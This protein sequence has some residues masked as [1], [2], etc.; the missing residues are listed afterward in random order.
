MSKLRF[1][2]RSF[3]QHVCRQA[4]I[5]YIRDVAL[6]DAKGW[7]PLGWRDGSWMRL[8]WVDLDG[9]RFVTVTKTPHEFIVHSFHKPVEILRTH[10]GAV[11]I[12][13]EETS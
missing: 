3:I 12:E 7:Q 10:S 6:D 1:V 11:C 13:E 4:R 8:E 9:K 5:E 2:Q